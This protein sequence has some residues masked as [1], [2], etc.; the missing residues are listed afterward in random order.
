MGFLGTLLGFVLI[1]AITEPERFGHWVA[2]IM[3][4]AS[5]RDPQEVER[6]RKWHQKRKRTME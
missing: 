1:W 2:R 6:K 5:M 4:G 3:F